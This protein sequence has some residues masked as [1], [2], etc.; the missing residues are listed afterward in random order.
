[1]PLHPGQIKYVEDTAKLGSKI[2]ILVPSNR[3]GKTSVAAC[4]QIWYL[5][6]KFGIPPGNR[7][8]WMK[9]LYRTANVAPR[10]SLV[11]PVFTYIDQ[12]LTS[13][14]PIRL[15]D[16]R[17]ITNKCQIEWFY[18]KHKTQS[19]PPMKQYF[20]NNSYIE[21]RTLGATAADSLEGKPFG[22]ITYDE[23]G[24]SHHLQQ[25]VDGT[26][27]ARLFDWGGPLHILST[28][29]QTSPSILF[30]Y[31]LYQKGL[32]QIDRHYTME[33]ELKDN[34]FFP[35]EQIEEQYALYAG[36]PLED[37]VL[38]G[39]FVFGGDNI[40]NA[41]DILDA[42]DPDLND[43]IRRQDGHDYIFSTDTAIGSDE[44]VHMVWDVTEKPFKIVRILAAKGNSKS[45]Q[46]H[47]NDFIDLW[48][49]YRTDNSNPKYILETWNGES[50]RYYHDLPEHIKLHTKCYGSWQPER[51]VS[52]NKNQE[53]PI[54]SPA[55]KADIL[56]ALSKLLS[57]KELKIPEDPDTVQQL[58]IYKE[59]DK[60]LPT[61]R[62]MALALGAWLATEGVP[63][64][65]EVSFVD[66]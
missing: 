3:W 17:L 42:K 38:R 45:P 58:G 31:E 32:N 10:S 65:T 55:K 62:V 36:N 2:N 22:L 13:T 41:Q 50:V 37:Q 52:E 54:T 1:M 44:M 64:I 21:H 53:R 33:G 28:P 30:H 47:L 4:I 19:A 48:D 59:D 35:K 63:V 8:S 18:L 29:D 66:W 9:A 39:K 5:F 16:G 20:S 24:R 40:F 46:K 25:E 27:L 23:G 15:P 6:Y 14:F 43:G 51:R 61:D 7:T 56:M 60:N 26:I 12:I 34:I 11:E 57:A 49:S